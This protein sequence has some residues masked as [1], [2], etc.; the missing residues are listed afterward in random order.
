MIT[1]SLFY[2]LFTTFYKKQTNKKPPTANE[3][4]HEKKKTHF[5]LTFTLHNTYLIYIYFVLCIIS[6]MFVL[7]KDKK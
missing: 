7:D 1:D 5:I 6:T 4:V 2:T 3:N